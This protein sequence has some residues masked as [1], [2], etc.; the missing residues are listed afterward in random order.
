[1]LAHK[2]YSYVSLAFTWSRTL[3]CDCSVDHKIL[4]T[5]LATCGNPIMF[6]LLESK[7][8]IPSISRHNTLVFKQSISSHDTSS[9][10]HSWNSTPALE[11]INVMGLPSVAKSVPGILGPTVPVIKLLN[12]QTN[13]NSLVTMKRI[14][15]VVLLGTVCCILTIFRSYTVDYKLL[16]ERNVK[17]SKW[18]V[19]WRFGNWDVYGMAQNLNCLIEVMNVGAGNVDD[20]KVC[21]WGVR[22][23]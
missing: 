7:S 13:L 4:W 11:E 19:H 3:N 16:N 20:L 1:M 23:T 21:G 14:A 18:T 17:F 10:L 9:T 5:L 6:C 2:M 12:S 15:F 8:R 22:Q